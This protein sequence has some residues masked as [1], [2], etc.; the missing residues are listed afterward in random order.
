MLPRG[1]TYQSIARWFK[2]G[3][4]IYALATKYKCEPWAIEVAIRTVMNR[5]RRQ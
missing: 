4:S 2:G 1:V 5:Q 3:W